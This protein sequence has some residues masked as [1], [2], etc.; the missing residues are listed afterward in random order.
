MQYAAIADSELAMKLL[1]EWCLEYSICAMFF[2]L[3]LFVSIN[4]LFLSKILLAIL[5]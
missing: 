5:F 1:K 2:S 3:S 4:A